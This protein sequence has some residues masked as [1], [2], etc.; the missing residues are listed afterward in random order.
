MKSFYSRDIDYRC[1]LNN[2]VAAKLLSL[3]PRTSPYAFSPSHSRTIVQRYN[4]NCDL[5]LLWNH[6]ISPSA[7]DSYSIEPLPVLHS[8]LE[9]EW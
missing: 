8:K 7:K 1:L 2:G 6:T 3:K 4:I 5:L 9:F